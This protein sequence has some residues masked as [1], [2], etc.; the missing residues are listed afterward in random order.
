MKKS[1]EITVFLSMCLLCISALLCVML[2]SARTAGSKYYF[3]AA[4]GGA[5]DTLFSR[6][7][8]RLWERYR[9]FA[10]EYD[11]EAGIVQDLEKYINEYLSVD[12]WYPM[13]LEAVDI[14]QLTQIADNKGEYLAEEAL[15][16]MKFGAVAQFFT[17]P[18][19]GEQLL[20]DITEGT[21]VHSLSG[22]YDNQ[23]RGVRK[24]EQAVERL[25]CNV[26]EQE[27][28]A[29]EIAKALEEDNE[30]AFFREAKN[31]REAAKKYPKLMRQYEAQAATLTNIQQKSREKIDQVKPDLQDGREE[32]LKQQ[33]NPYDDYIAQNGER[34]KGFADWERSVEKNLA[35]L[36]ETEQIVEE[37][38][39]YD[40]EDDEP[41]LDA[42][43]RF[44]R[45][46]YT[47]SNFTAE[48]GYADKEKQNL[49]DQV[50]KLAEGG[51]LEAVMPEG[52]VISSRMLPSGE[53]L[54]SGSFGAQS[55]QTGGRGMAEQ[56]LISEYCGLFFTDALKPADNPLQYEIEYLLQGSAADRENLE[57]TVTELFAVREGLNLLHILSDAQKRQEAEALALVITGSTGLMPLVKIVAC[58]I[59]GVWAMGE[60]IQDLWILMAGGKVPLWKQKGDWSLDLEGILDMGRGQMPDTGTA[61]EGTQTER[62]GFTYEGYLKLLLLKENPQVKYMRM[63]DMMQ[64]NIGRE[65]PGFSV[66]KCAYRVDIHSRACGK[67]VFFSLPFV[68]NLVNG[69]EGYYLDAVGEKAY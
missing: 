22:A 17:D 48:A 47:G 16:Y 52:T 3:Q 28:A 39:D 61:M 36:D 56:V 14:I 21:G 69:K 35:L 29:E 24:L 57:K 26:Q 60:S 45:A 67:H 10:L 1:G 7:H 68:E 9:I 2:E 62:R 64:I 12:N 41:S 8:R 43:Y 6:Y 13:R 42:A 59:M 4:A 40:Q 23:E 51:L 15:D 58:V 34:R 20:R 31:Y 19:Q 50:K 63:L 54:P 32:L 25:I 38:G 46:E 18:D 27:Q 30:T 66:L 65:E 49:L 5:L 53:S 33:W 37:S 11:S 55:G 44:W